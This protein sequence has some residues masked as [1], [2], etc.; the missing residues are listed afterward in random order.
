MIK[1]LSC[2]TG[3]H[4]IPLVLLAAAVCAFGSFTALSLL[5]RARDEKKGAIDWRW[6]LASSAVAGAAVWSTHF[7]AM[8]AY[9]P[10]SLQLGYKIG[11]TALSIAIAMVMTLAGF[12]I[13]L[14]LQAPLM[15]GAVFGI[16]I[17]S[18]HFTGM[19]A[20]TAPATPDWDLVYVAASLVIGDRRRRFGDAR[21]RPRPRVARRS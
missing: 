4:S 13:V 17:G 20:L 8:L 3:Q 1:V 9:E 18:M 14:Y 5:E 15:G 7:V 12:A 19:K 11:L 6:L 2:I 21:L 10:S 16:A